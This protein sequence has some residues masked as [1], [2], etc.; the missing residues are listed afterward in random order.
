MSRVGLYDRL[1]AYIPAVLLHQHCV[2]R[3]LHCHHDKQRTADLNLS[4]DMSDMRGEGGVGNEG[5]GE[6]GE[7]ERARKKERE[8]ERERESILNFIERV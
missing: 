7:R 4:A 3:L 8:R 6:E 1:H 5:G 2:Q